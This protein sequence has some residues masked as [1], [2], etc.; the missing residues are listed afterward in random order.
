MNRDKLPYRRNC[1]GYFVTKDKI[2]AQDTGKG[3]I[4]FPGGGVDKGEHADLA[5]LREAQEETGAVINK[6]IK[7]LG[8]IHFLWDK[9]WIKSEKQKKRYQR[10]KG[11]EMHFF[12]GNIKCF[13]ENEKKHEDYWQGQKLMPIQRVIESI[14]KTKPFSENIKLYRET[15]LKY[16][17]QL[18]KK[19]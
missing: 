16:L 18:L 13:K 19:V 17:K 3:Y 11:E 12:F 2:L 10:F 9:D 15:Q 14:E 7:K 8:E 4:V 6:P 5:V 1:E